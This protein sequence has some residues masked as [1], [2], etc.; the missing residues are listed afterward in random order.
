MDVRFKGITSTHRSQQVREQIEQAI[1]RGDF[2]A[3]DRLPSERDLV[4][5]FGVSRVSVREAIRSLEA[6]GLV[7]V[8]QGRGCF[9]SEAYGNGYAAPF[10]RWLAVHR[11][12]VLD[13]LKVRGALD[14]LAAESAAT[15]RDPA[16]VEAVVGASREFRAAAEAGVEL[17]TIVELDI[18]FHE[19]IAAASGSEL[20]TRLVRDL[21]AYLG[22]SRAVV[23]APKGR[24]QR[25]AREHEKIVQA[26]V[27]RRP[28][29][30]K[31][32]AARHLDAVRAAIAELTEKTDGT[33][34]A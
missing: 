15:R 28:G 34:A 23:L 4:E 32:A 24:P 1:K 27:G 11:E 20:L 30:A 17:A 18:L 14:E 33:E 7:V 12:E 22:E 25:S 13:L 10:A 2:K 31:A 8:H 6:L 3:G 26:I 29:E 5:Q 16:D 9:V 19:A 21:N